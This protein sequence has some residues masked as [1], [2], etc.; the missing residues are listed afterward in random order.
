MRRLFRGR[1]QL[2]RA[3]WDQAQADGFTSGSKVHVDGKSETGNGSNGVVAK[4][5]GGVR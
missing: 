5:G 2:Q 4:T 3:R 1:R